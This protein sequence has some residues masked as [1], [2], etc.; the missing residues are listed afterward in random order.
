MSASENKQVHWLFGVFISVIILLVAL[1]TTGMILKYINKDPEIPTPEAQNA[2][3]VNMFSTRPITRPPIIIGAA[4]QSI[5]ISNSTVKTRNVCETP[6]CIALA[7]HLHNFQDTS[8]DPCQ[9]FYKSVCGKYNEHS[10]ISGQSRE[11]NKIVAQLVTEYLDKNLSTTSKS[12]NAMKLYYQKCEELRTPNNTIRSKLY[13]E[14]LKGMYKMVSKIG[15]WPLFWRDFYYINEI[16]LDQDT[17]DDYDDEIDDVFFEIENLY[18]KNKTSEESDD[19]D[20][21]EL[22]KHVPSVDFERI[23]KN[24]ISPL[25][26]DNIWKNIREKINSERVDYFLSETKNLESLLKTTSQKRLANFL[27]WNYL[28]SEA[29]DIMEEEREMRKISCAQRVIGIFPLAALRIFVRNHF[30]KENLDI[31]SEMT[32]DFRR[33][34]KEMIEESTWLSENTK[35]SALKKLK[36]IKKTIGYPKEMDVPGALDSFFEPLNLSPTDSY[37][38]IQSKVKKFKIE[39]SMDFIASLLPIQSKPDVLTVNAFYRPNE[40]SLTINIPRIDA[41][42][43]DS[44]YPVY[45]KIA[46]LGTIIGHEMGHGFDPDGRKFDEN[47]KKRNWWTPEDSAE[48][49][50]RAQCLVDQYDNYDDPDFGKNLNGTITIEEMVA[51]II[52]INT[53]WRA[54]KKI[55]LTNE[56]K[57]I[58]FEDYSMDKLFYRLSAVS[59]CKTRTKHSLKQQ[60][61]SVH[62]T[63]SFRVNGLFSN[64]KSFAEAFNCPVG[65]PMNPKK[66]CELF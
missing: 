30:D 53:S 43:F 32:E 49:D 39:Q 58:G 55:D 37:Y 51:D 11:K 27:I 13:N 47:G 38:V 1:L 46:S 8:V 36:M 60:L 44:S 25:R 52:G 28:A 65:S 20:L 54:Y 16:T 7:H 29:Y 9:N 14:K 18:K 45:A 5:K 57:I 12:E 34:F 48:Y 41:P 59:S 24:Y 2:S 6:E 40:N 64:M 10:S 17:F 62:P 61:E 31:V 42:F 22:Q 33:S 3:D 23:I 56:P 66:K 50:R 26:K 35:K 63:N 21:S 15:K 4:T 19:I